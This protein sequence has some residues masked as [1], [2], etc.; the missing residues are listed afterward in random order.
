MKL[1]KINFGEK[2]RLTSFLTNFYSNLK[3]FVT[4]NFKI[5][6]YFI[7]FF[8]FFN[9]FLFF[10]SIFYF[11]LFFSFFFIFLHFSSIFHQFFLH[12]PSIVFNSLLGTD[13]SV[14]LSFKYHNFL[15][16][17][18]L[19]SHPSL[20]ILKSFH[21]HIR[22]IFRVFFLYKKRI[23]HSLLKERFFFCLTTTN[24]CHQQIFFYHYFYFYSPFFVIM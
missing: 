21:F 9:F 2:V 4:E 20:T 17:P 12:F 3:F 22:H 7:N 5:F 23:F 10:F 19:T 6:H 8:K 18:Q 11:F 1:G 13:F 15:I 24:S 16:I 14:H